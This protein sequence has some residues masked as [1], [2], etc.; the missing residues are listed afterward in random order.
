MFAA[1]DIETSGLFDGDVPPDVTCCAVRI[2]ASA[3]PHIRLFHSNWAAAMT[4]DDLADLVE[5]LYALHL[6]GVTIVTFNGAGFDFK[7]LWAHLCGV[8]SL[9]TM[10]RELVQGH[11]D[12]MFEFASR[13]GYYTSMQS[14]SLGTGLP[15]KTGD[16]GDAIGMWCGAAAT[17]TT[18]AAVLA[19]C[20]NDVRC[21]AE[22][23]RHICANGT[24]TRITKAGNHRVCEFSSPPDT[25]DAAAA[26]WRRSEVDLSWMTDP[27]QILEAVAWADV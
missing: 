16:G 8:P 21:L 15:G 17:A 14:L 3:T 12:L 13:H 5:Y 27:P 7:V 1:F 10:L 26:R 23:Y 18:R 9:C 2:E 22:L 19:Y 11:A 24:A 6:A 20:A 25:V 4:T